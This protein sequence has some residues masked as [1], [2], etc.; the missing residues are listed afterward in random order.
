VQQQRYLLVRA[1]HSAHISVAVEP[2]EEYALDILFRE[3]APAVESEWLLLATALFSGRLSW[4]Y[5]I[6]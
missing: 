4:L 2:E 1:L 5:E 3:L 6:Y